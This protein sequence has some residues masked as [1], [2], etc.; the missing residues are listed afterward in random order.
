ME[1]KDL[2]NNTAKDLLKMDKELR[3]ELFQLRLK[4]KT[5]QLTNKHR[6]QEVRRDLAR[7]QTKLSSL[8]KTGKGV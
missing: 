5:Q 1:Y 4:L 7:V 2:K 8:Q 6:V 3:D